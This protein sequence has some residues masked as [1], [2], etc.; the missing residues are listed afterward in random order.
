MIDDGP[1]TPANVLRIEHAR[2]GPTQAAGVPG[3]RVELTTY[4]LVNATVSKLHG[5]RGPVPSSNGPRPKSFVWVPASILQRALP[6][7]VRQYEVTK[8]VVY[9]TSC[10]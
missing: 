9:I 5:I 8:K 2:L 3:Y 1:F 6:K 4:S 7:L 10:R